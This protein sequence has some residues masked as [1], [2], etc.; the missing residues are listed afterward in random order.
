MDV[1]SIN[2][3]LAEGEVDREDMWPRIV[4]M[5]SRALQFRFEFGLKKLPTE[6]GLIYPKGTGRQDVDC[7]LVDWG[8][9]SCMQCHL[10]GRTIA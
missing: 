7:I 4:E 5:E 10:A 6:P 8:F 9:S 3:L 1:K 2:R